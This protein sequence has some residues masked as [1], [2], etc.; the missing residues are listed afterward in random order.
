MES[1]QRVLTAIGHHEPDR[2]PIDQGSMRSTGIM[3]IAYNRLKRH[4]G[5]SDGETRLYDVVQQLAEPEPWYL[6]RFGVDVVDLGRAF[7]CRGWK[8][9]R[10]PDGSAAVAPGW[11]DVGEEAD[12]SLT[13]RNAG[14]QAIGKMPSSGTCVDQTCWPLAGESGLREFEPLA[15]K[16]GQVTWAA[17]PSPPW[18]RPLTDERIAEFATV[19]RCLR[20]N[21]QFAVSL[22]IGCNLFEW[23]QFL[24]SMEQA[25]LHMAGEK[26]AFAHFL[27]RL[28]EHH[29]ATLHRL[30]PGLHGL[31]DVLVVG[32]DLGMQKG[33]QISRKMY[34]ELFFQRHKRIYEAAKKLSGAHI[35]LHSCGGIYE[36]IPDL[37]EAGVE[38]L[39]PVQTS[40]RN[41]DPA[42]LKQ[43]FG[44][45]VTFWGGGCDTQR[46]LPFGTPAEVREDVRRRME[47]FAPGGGFVWTQVHNIMADIPPE[48]IVAMLEA[49][50]EYG[51][52]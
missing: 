4:L 27:D 30:L 50:R 29:L 13:F 48:N 43:E 37:I 9:W 51:A 5:I 7:S 28:T 14:G 23:S 40:A 2:V 25:Y 49:A 21:S 33:P 16:M 18:D 32:D 17:L 20:E 36:L 10:L 19:A 47:I 39:N 8:P 1:R 35:F 11:L 26:E 34:R 41:M 3:A 42:R 15:E 22:S 44:R 38:I 31:I 24:F 45:D 46:V 52:V 12:G 6:E